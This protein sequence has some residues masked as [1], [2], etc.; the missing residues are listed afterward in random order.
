LADVRQPE[1]TSGRETSGDD[2][3]LDGGGALLSLAPEQDLS[4]ISLDPTI[5]PP[6]ERLLKPPLHVCDRKAMSV[7]PIR[8]QRNEKLPLL[9]SLD[10]DVRDAGQAAEPGSDHIL[11]KTAQPLRTDRADEL[12]G[13]ES[14]L[15]LQ[16]LGDLMSE[17]GDHALGKETP[18][19]RE[20]IGDLRDNAP[21][22]L[23]LLDPYPQKS[24]P[25]A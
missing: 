13:H 4:T 20:T 11:R 23:A 21:E 12:Q 2:E 1:G 9:A 10:G 5:R 25:L 24:L 18:D 6:R 16:G 3:T 15:V 14:L 19:G 22:A 17:A 7:E 8:I